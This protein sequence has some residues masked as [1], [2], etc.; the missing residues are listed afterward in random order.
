LLDFD[1]SPVTEGIAYGVRITYKLGDECLKRHKEPLIYMVMRSKFDHFLVLKAQEAGAAV[2]D[3]LKADQLEITASGVKVLTPKGPFT[4]QIVA[5]AD[6]AKGM[7]A[8]TLGLMRHVGLGLALEAEVSVT[9]DELANWD[10]IIGLDL[11]QIPGGYGWVFPKKDHLSI[12]VGGPVH[13][14]KMFEPYFRRLLRHLGNHEITDFKGHPMPLRKGGMAIQQDRFL[15]VGDAA[16]L[17]HPL[18]RE[19]IYYAIKSAQVAAPVIAG[20]LQAGSIN[21]ED[22]QNAVDAQLMPGLEVG[23]VLLELFTWSPRLY[24]NLVKRSDLVWRHACRALQGAS[25]VYA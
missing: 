11:G 1:I 6:G 3:G 15:L 10:S 12:G 13:L 8:K 9:E 20:A 23:R 22:Y 21:L 2:I 14:S 24:F 25:R 17:I 5:G 4:A 19:G 16:G 7:T 18:T